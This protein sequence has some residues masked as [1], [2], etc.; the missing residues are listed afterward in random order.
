MVWK[1]LKIP[2]SSRI[3]TT[4][5]EFNKQLPPALAGPLSYVIGFF[6][7]F[8][9][10]FVETLWKNSSLFSTIY[11]FSKTT[12]PIFKKGVPMKSP[13]H[14]ICLHNF[15]VSFYRTLFSTDFEV[16]GGEI[17][18]PYFFLYFLKTTLT[19]LKFWV[20]WIEQIVGSSPCISDY[21]QFY[22]TKCFGS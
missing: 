12:L 9:I 14:F 16:V 17:F 22:S 1:I 2:I 3:S 4:N 21:A 20:Y 19:N 7:C 18:D 8:L 5:S 15:L 10:F 13:L 11:F 6:Y